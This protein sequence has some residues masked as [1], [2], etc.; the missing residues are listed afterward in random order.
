[1]KKRAMRYSGLGLALLLPCLTLPSRALACVVGTG[2]GASCTEST[3][4]ACLPGGAGFTGTVSF[5]TGSACSITV[6]TTKTISASTTI[7]G[8]NGGHGVTIN[9]GGSIQIFSVNTGVNFTVQNL[10]IANGNTAS[11]G[12]GIFNNGGTLTVANSTFAGNSAGG[13]AGGIFNNAAGGTL[14]VTNSTF[15]GNSAGYNGGG[16]VNNGGTLTVTN[17]TFS[18]NSAL[19]G[20]GIYSGSGT[21]TVINTIIVNSTSG[22]NCYGTIT[23][24]GHN[25]EDGTTCGWGSG[26]GSLSSTN[27]RL[28]PAGLANNGGPTQTFALC[29]ATNVPTSGCVVSPAINAGNQTVCAA[30]PVSGKDQ[31]GYYRPG[32]SATNCSI[33]AFEA[34]SAATNYPKPPSR[35][36][37][38]R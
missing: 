38:S 27:P 15:S 8:T 2:T 11:Y 29:T 9:G 33:G 19:S 14:T 32:T 34:N 18:G 20:G 4:N 12:G 7:D 21:V 24:G 13:A 37:A 35:P 26:S 30:S 3:L 16:I 25:I 6:T 36:K 10:T 23:N 17:S 5:N 1:M 28:D 31:R 22:G